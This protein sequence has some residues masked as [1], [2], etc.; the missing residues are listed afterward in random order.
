MDPNQ[1]PPPNPPNYTPPQGGSPPQPGYVPGPQP[2]AAPAGQ[3][4]AMQQPSGQPT[5]PP[6]QPYSPTQPAQPQ[7]GAPRPAPQAPNSWYT[8]SPKPDANRPSDAS[9]YLQAA[10]VGAPA[11]QTQG[12]SNAGA[13]GQIINGQYSVD[14][15]DQVAGGSTGGNQQLDK[16]FIFIGAG[17]VVALLV[18]AALIFMRPQAA[19]DNKPVELYTALIDTEKSTSKSGKILK[20]SSLVSINSSIRT[21]LT[22]AARDMEEPLGAMGQKPAA[23]KS[24]ATKPPYH[25]EKFAAALEDARLNAVYDRVYANEINT[26][27]KY[28]IAYMESIKKSTRSK[29]MNE[30]IDKNLPS[31]QTVQKAVDEY[32]KSAEASSY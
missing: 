13:P 17:L 18:A 21:N 5:T 27:L 22:N 32:Q 10:G 26:K 6:A 24:A 12:T 23:L 25:D 20:S 4:P 8:P 14:Y 19:A 11:S 30:F 15:L 31:F 2:Y 16:K 9:S 29:S 1:T 28:I 7:P 3:Q